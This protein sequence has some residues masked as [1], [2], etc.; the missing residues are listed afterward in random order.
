MRELDETDAVILQ[1]LAEDGRRPYSEIGEVVDLTPPA[2]SDRVSRLQEAGVIQQFTIDVDR[3]TLQG[4][5][6][7]LVRVDPS[8]GALSAVRG[9]LVDA[10]AT[11]H[12][13]TTAA[14]S[15]V[16][17]ARTDDEAV[18]EWVAATVSTD[19][20][21]D[22]SVDLVAEAEWTPDVDTTGFELECA[23]CGNTVTS[24]G[25]SA[26]VGGDLHHFC[27]ASC[28]SA[29]TDRFERMEQAAEAER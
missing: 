13:F 23:E 9:A 14:G 22:Y 18:H 6:P 20:L 11:E 2:V 27:C 25:T 21:D 28:E 8:P 16:A 24:E 5:I 26:R 1:L 15:V 4:G 3:S 29:F 19:A 7:V 10:E 17:F 12:V